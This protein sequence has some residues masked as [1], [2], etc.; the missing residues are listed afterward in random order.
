[1]PQSCDA[2]R[3]LAS[4]PCT[5]AVN[6]MVLAAA[7]TFRRALT[8]LLDEHHALAVPVVLAL[9]RLGQPV[10]VGLDEAAF[11]EPV[12]GLGGEHEDAFQAHGAGALLDALENLLAVA[13][14]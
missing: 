2:Q 14:A 1:M 6:S 12:H 5:I 11:E 10:G 13:L 4:I 8:Q 3:D 9:A 7:K